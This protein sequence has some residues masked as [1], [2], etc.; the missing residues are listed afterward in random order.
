VRIGALVAHRHLTFDDGAYGVS[1]IDMRH[2]MLPYRDLISSQGPLHYP[3]LYVGDWLSGHLR[4]GPR[5]TPILAGVVAPI[6]VWAIAR[7]MGSAPRVAVGVGIVVAVT[8]SMVWA[9]G[10]ISGDGPA[11]ALA[12]WAVWAAIAHRDTPSWWRACLA[13]A[14]FGGA[15]ATKSLVFPA[16][17][18]IASYLWCRRRLLDEVRAGATA[19]GTWF[20]AAVPWGLRDVWDQSIAFHLH[21]R[22]DGSPLVQFAEIGRWLVERDVLLVGIAVLAAVGAIRFRTETFGART[23]VPRRTD[24]IVV[25]GWAALTVVTLGLEK[26]LLH[27]H[28]AVLVPPL[29]LMIAVRPPPRRWLV[30]ALIVLVPLQALELSGIVTPGGYRGID[31]ELVAALR[32]LPRDARVISDVQGFVWQSGHATPRLLNDNSNARIQQH[33]VTAQTI[34]AAAADPSTCAVIIWSFRFDNRIPALREALAGIGYTPRV[35]ARGKEL[36]LKPAGDVRA[37]RAS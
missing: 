9:T 23:S 36:W 29:A 20:A 22:W 13:G 37:C 25:S 3:L 2:G 17:V 11:C 1:T 15:V 18:P 24:A 8:G 21:K 4:N 5:V 19:I 30:A 10:P 34:S 26:L 12:V 16:V 28:L 7:R 33:L 32:Q 35:F 14:L 6:G 27:S 31:A